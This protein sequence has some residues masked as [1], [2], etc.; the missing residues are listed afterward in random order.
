MCIRDR[1]KA[2]ISAD[3]YFEDYA[4]APWDSETKEYVFVE[5]IKMREDVYKRQAL[6]I[7]FFCVKLCQF[8]YLHHNIY[9]LSRRDYQNSFCQPI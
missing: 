7:V 8:K 2:D 1:C 3:C 6:R 9:L 4:N 5:T